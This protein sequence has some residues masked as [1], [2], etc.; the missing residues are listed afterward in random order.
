MPIKSQKLETIKYYKQVYPYAN[1][2]SMKKIEAMIP[3]ERLSRVND[4]LKK[5]GIGGLTCF[6]TKGRGQVPIQKRSAGRGGVFTPEFNTNCSILVVVKDSD[7]DKT[8]NAIVNAAST[9]LAGEGKIFVSK[10]DEALDIG[11]NKKGDSAL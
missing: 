3:A 1:G 10:V 2:D 4:E 6:D 7:L 11:T 8:I 9:G 5:I